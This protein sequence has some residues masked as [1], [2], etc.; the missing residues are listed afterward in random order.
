M[1]NIMYHFTTV[2][3]LYEMLDN[4]FNI[5]LPSLTLTDDDELS[6]NMFDIKEDNFNIRLAL[7]VDLLKNEY[8]NYDNFDY[9]N[10][11]NNIKIQDYLKNNFKKKRFNLRN[12]IIEIYVLFYNEK[13]I[14]IF[15]NL[16]YKLINTDIKING[17]KRWLP[18]D[19][20]KQIKYKGIKFEL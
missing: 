16:K 10:T 15:D 2:E 11:D 19:C 1:P 20:N 3:K 17:L 14:D 18:F 4:N 13:L 8:E 9:I 12:S 7:D 5:S 6:R